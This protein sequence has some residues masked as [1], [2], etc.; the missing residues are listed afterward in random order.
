MSTGNELAM[1][2]GT[3]GQDEGAPGL[4]DVHSGQFWQYWGKAGGDIDNYVNGNMAS[5]ALVGTLL[6]GISFGAALEPPEFEDEA[7]LAAYGVLMNLSTMSDVLLIIISLCFV[8]H[9]YSC[10]NYGTR[11]NFAGQFGYIVPLTSGLIILSFLTILAGLLLVTRELYNDECFY[12]SLVIVLVFLL[13]SGYLN[14]AIP[15]W[16]HQNYG[17]EV[18]EKMAEKTPA[19]PSLETLITNKSHLEIIKERGCDNTDQL[20]EY[21]AEHAQSDSIIP[22]LGRYAISIQQFG[23]PPFAALEI[24][25]GLEV[26]LDQ[27]AWNQK[28]KS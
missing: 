5:I 19:I 1:N 8:L 3:A 9:Y 20:I 23:I 10:T 16:N 17:P 26:Y 13:Y 6:I 25:K 22:G 4:L 14:L 11:L 12:I 7:N 15:H 18:Q 27:H 24:V 28:L 2:P 21:V